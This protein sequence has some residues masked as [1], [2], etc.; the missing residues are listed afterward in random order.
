MSRKLKILYISIFMGILILPSAAW[1][2][3]SMLGHMGI[4]SMDRIDNDL[5]ENRYKNEIEAETV[6]EDI[7]EQL[8]AYYSDRI[9]FRSGIV[10]LNR[11]LNGTIERPYNNYIEKVYG[12]AGNGSKTVK[13]D[14]T[15][16]IIEVPS[17]TEDGDTVYM[18]TQTE[19]VEGIA[20]S[21]STDTEGEAVDDSESASIGAEDAGEIQNSGNTDETVSEPEELP[22]Y[23]MR[24]V[25]NQVII[26]R[27]GWL[28]YGVAKSRDTQSRVNIPTEEELYD[29]SDALVRLQNACDEHGTILRIFVCPE[30]ETVYPEY[31]PTVEREN[32]KS[33]T[34]VVYDHVSQNTDTLMIYP[35]ERFETA[36]KYYQIY[37]RLD[38]HW[39]A[40][41]GYI[42]TRELMGTLNIDMNPLQMVPCEEYVPVSGD[43]LIL[44]NLDDS[45]YGE[46]KDYFIDYRP[47][48]TCE[49][50]VSLDK[51]DRIRQY[52]SDAAV[53]GSFVMVGDSFNDQMLKYISRD[54]Q[55]TVFIH[56]SEH[57]DDRIEEII[58]SADV[59]V[60]EIVERDLNELP[61]LA[62]RI[63]GCIRTEE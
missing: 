37:Y 1:G 28:F 34:E 22:Y 35:L 48:V 10:I 23:P 24:I 13:E 58:N 38:S 8:E 61:E 11:K 32:D 14:D 31:Y 7:T 41:G 16:V 20:Q 3:I 33:R 5:G 52:G 42:A 56:R 2:V 6:T 40:A 30:K 21:V 36:K 19:G 18:S 49:G 12:N 51:K 26:G 39:N 43:L 4:V 25:N 57:L 62:D 44:G 59:L 15:G 27:E 9:P 47:E 60:I 29:Y 55:S 53:E 46:D 50:P 54:Y 17:L 63:T 45:G